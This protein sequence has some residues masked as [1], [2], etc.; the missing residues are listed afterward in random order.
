M[1]DQRTTILQIVPDLD[2]GGAEKSAVEIAAAVVAAG[3]RGL[4]ASQGGRMEG[5]LVATGGELIR[6]PAAT[7]N[8]IQILRNAS[9]LA[10][11]IR[12]EKVALV[13]AR[14]RAPAWSALLAARRTGIPFVTTYHGA[15]SERGR[16]KRLYNSVMARADLVIANSRYT[17][18]LI[19]ARYGTPADRLRVIHRGVDEA[20]DP[21]RVTP[22][23]LAAVRARWG[24]GADDRV[25]LQA[26]RLT[27]W[28][29]QGVL[30][31]AA[32]K[33]HRE[34]RLPDDVRIVLAGDA[35]GRH[36]Y[37]AE[38]EQQISA[39]N[40]DGRVLL[41][42][43][44]NDIAAA[45]GASFASVVASTEPEAFGRSAAE[46]QAMA[47]PVIATRLG[48]PPETVLARPECPAAEATGWLVP[49]GD[50]A[51]LADTLAEALALPAAEHDAMGRR[52]RRHVL[53]QFTLQA[54]QSATLGAYD[55][56]LGTGLCQ[57]FAA[58]TQRENPEDHA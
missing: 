12:T 4:V 28:K 15:Y 6:F 49:P 2:T 48:A 54:M 24:T 19:E 31:G 9:R 39:A 21:A 1:A 11:I 45:F 34:G 53:S 42:G 13:H 14:S 37:L 52:G 41:V 33:L 44:E 57:A 36:D 20:Y 35:Q 50:A 32:G 3:G 25:V 16:L 46:S 23:R 8:P 56:L 7:K 17:A 43:H 27:N 40:L 47:C 38:L 5:D 51:A 30:I 18:G 29:G 10:D 26:A 55:E 22:E 58:A